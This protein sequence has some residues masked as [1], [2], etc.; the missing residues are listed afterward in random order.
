M[1]KRKGAPLRKI[2]TMLNDSYRSNEL[3]SPNNLF[4]RGAIFKNLRLF[5]FLLIVATLF[6]SC[7]TKP[8]YFAP[9]PESYQRLVYVPQSPQIKGVQ[10]AKNNMT[11]E[12][13]FEPTTG[14]PLFNNFA[15]FWVCAVNTDAQAFEYSINNIQVVDKDGKSLPILG[16]DEVVKRYYANAAVK[17]ASYALASW[18]LAAV[19]NKVFA[20]RNTQGTVSGY[21]TQG[22]Y[23]Y[24][25]YQ[26]KTTDPAVSY[27]IYQDS[28]QRIQQNNEYLEQTVQH[29]KLL[30]EQLTLT[31]KIL[32]KGQGAFGVI[33]VPFTTSMP[34]PNEFRFTVILGGDSFQHCFTIKDRP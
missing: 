3:P 23:Y 30:A 1:P 5:F 10:Q 31:P 19:E 24:G 25:T 2:K 29:A 17:E 34:T 21:D 14:V 12:V 9:A 32:D 6:S 18:F 26:G 28:N 11:S 15:M 7:A 16:L 4:H 27:Q 8:F 33:A 13:Y 20:T 22:N